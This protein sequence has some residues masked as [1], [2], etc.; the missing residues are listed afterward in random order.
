MSFCIAQIAVCFQGSFWPDHQ[1][2]KKCRQVQ[3][4]S[5]WAARQLYRLWS[6]DI[7]LIADAQGKQEKR[8]ENLQKGKAHKNGSG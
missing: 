3:G 4:F 2:E 5:M 8:R 6:R 1:R 7:E